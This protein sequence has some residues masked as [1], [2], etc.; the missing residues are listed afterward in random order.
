ME[1]VNKI[2]SYKIGPVSFLAITFIVKP[3]VLFF[4]WNIIAMKFGYPEAH[5]NVF[6]AFLI[7]FGL[8][9]IFP[10]VQSIRLVHTG[11]K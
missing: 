3:L 2:F 9:S 6:Q 1:E 8:A 4:A 11:I 10:E 7:R 5:I